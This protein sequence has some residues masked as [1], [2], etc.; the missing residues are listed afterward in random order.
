MRPLIKVVEDDDIEDILEQ[1]KQILSDV[2]ML[3]DGQHLKDVLFETGLRCGKDGR[4]RFPRDIIDRAISSTPRQI[5]LYDRDGRLHTVLGGD[6][7]HFV[8]GS[9]GLKVLD[10]RSGE[11]RAAMTADFVD[12]VRLADGLEHI[13]YLATAFSTDEVAEDI[14]DAWRLYLTLTNSRKP[15]VSGAFT[16]YGVPRMGEMMQIF[17]HDR[18]DLI[19]RPMSI[20]TITPTGIF[21]YSEDSCQNLIDCVRLGI[22]IEITPVTLMGLIAPVTVFEAAVFQTAD[23]LAGLTIAQIV[24]PGTPVLFGGAPAAFNMKTTTA[25]M[26][27]IEALRLN[28]ACA[29]VAK[30]LGL[31][32]Q[33][34]MALSDAKL[35][36]AQ[37]GGETF[38]SAVLAA[39]AGIN[40][41]SGPGMLD[42][43]LVF[44]LAKLVLDNEFCGQALQFVREMEVI[45]PLPAIDL[46]RQVIAENHL[47]TAE[48]TLANW[49]QHLYL[50]GPVFD[51]QNRDDW[52]KNGSTSL[53][54]RARREVEQRLAAYIPVATDPRAVR[55]LQRILRSGREE[56]LDLPEIP[57]AEQGDRT[58]VMEARRRRRRPR[59]QV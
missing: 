38:S 26:A 47:L 36:D 43:V 28:L 33:A 18:Q 5:K 21:R 11:T 22:P 57:I 41:V 15:M 14:A 10:H 54:Q 32:T 20:F 49:P 51:R 45:D 40:S 12:F 24:S 2:G 35:V 53:L 48:H 37:A 13:A 58:Q 3:I 23:V 52:T 30:S 27:S 19:T 6:A 59:R 39:L 44:S 17:R 56:E 8:P 34:Y 55:E 42:Y 46:A 25:P 31:P 1:A 29:A 9:S 16:G 7:V 4:I 50:P